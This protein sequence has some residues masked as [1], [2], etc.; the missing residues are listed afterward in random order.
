M[1]IS[2]HQ[3]RITVWGA[4]Y[5]RIAGGRPLSFSPTVEP[6]KKVVINFARSISHPHIFYLFWRLAMRQGPHIIISGEFRKT[7]LFGGR[8]IN[9]GEALCRGTIGTMVNSTAPGILRLCAR[10]ISRRI[11]RPAQNRAFDAEI[12]IQVI[13]AQNLT[14]FANLCY[15]ITPMKLVSDNNIL[16]NLMWTDLQSC[17]ISFCY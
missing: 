4:L 17:V 10:R 7:I 2:L 6:A 5:H 11:V 15:L 12:V 13:F 16:C 3:R 8:A 9:D 14:F 1:Y